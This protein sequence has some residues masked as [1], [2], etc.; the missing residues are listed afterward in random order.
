M[1]SNRTDIEA[2]LSEHYKPSFITVQDESSKHNEAHDSHFNLYLVSEEFEG[3]SLIK[4]YFFC[5]GKFKKK[6]RH[7]GIK[8]LLIQVGIMDR[9]HALSIVSRTAVEHEKATTGNFSPNC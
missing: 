2:C 1:F 9:I 7:K 8:G 3:L 5:C 6:N 4:R